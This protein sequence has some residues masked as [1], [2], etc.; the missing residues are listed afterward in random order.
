MAAA[1]GCGGAS[2]GGGATVIV[3]DSAGIEIVE[4]AAPLWDE[5]SAWRLSAEPVLRL[6]VID[7]PEELTFSSVTDVLSRA[8]G[9]LV[10]ADWNARELRFF[11]EEGAFLGRAGRPGEGPGE[12]GRIHA[13]RAYRGDSVVAWDGVR[14][15]LTVLSGDGSYGRTVIPGQPVRGSVDVHTLADGSFLRVARLTAGLSDDRT[16]VVVEATRHGAAGELIDSLGSYFDHEVRME[17][18]GRIPVRLAPLFE[19]ITEIVPAGSG[20]VVGTADEYEVLHY[21]IAGTEVRRARWSGPDRTTRPADAERHLESI[22]GRITN[23]EV[24]EAAEAMFPKAPVRDRFPAYVTVLSD[25]AGN[26][27]LEEYLR[28]GEEGPNRW[29]VLDAAGGWLGEVAFPAGFEVRSVGLDDV[30][31]V[32]S[33]SLDVTYVHRYRLIK[34]G[35]R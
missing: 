20:Y 32:M 25:P 16:G 28:P 26:I 15:R 18:H 30:V 8:D 35:V 11:G 17:Q 24:R 31:G 3:R 33:D 12:F 14:H 13:V 29:T 22:I 21:D 1:C 27:W 23:E 4:S 34:P 19:S 10:V 2:S 7:G 5:D 9:S 6:G